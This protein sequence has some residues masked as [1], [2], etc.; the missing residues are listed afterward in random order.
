MGLKL[1][2]SQFIHQK[3]AYALE[4]KKMHVTKA[5]SV[6]LA[7]FREEVY[8]DLLSGFPSKKVAR[9]ARSARRATFLLSYTPQRAI[10]LIIHELQR[11]KDAKFFTFFHFS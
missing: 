2:P 8:L 11:Q 9:R 3:K 7:I 4:N 10:S 6:N 1:P 5:L